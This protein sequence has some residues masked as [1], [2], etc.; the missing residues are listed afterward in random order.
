MERRRDPADAAPPALA[1]ERILA[2]RVGRI[3]GLEQGAV[4]VDFPGNTRGALAAR[5]TVPITM[6]EQ[7]VL[8]T[9]EDGDPSRPIVVGVMQ[10]PSPTMVDLVLADS[11]HALREA[12]LA[13]ADA[14]EAS[15]VVDGKRL[16]LEAEEEVV[17]KC[18]EA[19]ITLRKDG[20][21]VIRGAYVESYAAGTNRIKGGSVRIN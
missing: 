16:V 19:S 12:T 6:G 9:F 5:S 7:E 17:L 3:V 20:R 14:G 4:R 11:S 18:G 15:A 8:L 21:V 1:E 10:E 13:S 2:P